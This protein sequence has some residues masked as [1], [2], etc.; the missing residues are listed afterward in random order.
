VGLAL[1]A[2]NGLILTWIVMASLTISYVVGV[3]ASIAYALLVAFLTYVLLRVTACVNCPH[4]GK[5]CPYGF[6]RLAGFFVRGRVTSEFAKPLS[7][8]N[9]VLLLTILPLTGLA[10]GLLLLSYIPSWLAI[11]LP[12]TI[13]AGMA[14]HALTCRRCSAGDR[15]PFR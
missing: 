15:C 10:Y 14:E 13:A 6:D 9:W 4:M 3:I 5:E 1:L 7:L 2:R 11:L 8:I 12:V